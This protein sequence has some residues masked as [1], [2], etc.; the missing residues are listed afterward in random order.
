MRHQ[1]WT[2]ALALVMLSSSMGWSADPSSM[3]V[4]DPTRPSYE[5]STSD[6]G[7]VTSIE[8][9]GEMYRIEL[10]GNL[11]NKKQFKVPRDIEVRDPSNN[12]V[13]ISQVKKGSTITLNLQDGQVTQIFLNS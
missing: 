7:T 3:P 5:S 11:G 9:E 2:K 4:A 13:P 8:K 10:N 12:R 1:V 6:Q